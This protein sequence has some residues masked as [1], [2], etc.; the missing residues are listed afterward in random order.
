MKSFLL[1]FASCC[2]FTFQLKAQDNTVI[3]QVL[4]VQTNAWNN[5]DINA[6]MQTYWK[7]DSLL[8]VSPSGISHGW[9]AALYRYKKRYPGK[10]AM[11]KLNFDIVQMQQLSPVYYFVVG[12]WH[13]TRTAGN[14][15][16]T[17]TLLLKNINGDWKITCDH[18]D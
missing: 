5:G 14:L 15:N 12:R 18:S 13:L 6:F 4:Q 8:F 7:S 17:F 3:K 2:C 1:L 10:A 11:G 9:V 16:G